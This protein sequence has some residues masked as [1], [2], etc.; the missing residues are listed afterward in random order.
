MYSI[1]HNNCS[2]ATRDVA[3]GGE[4]KG[5]RGGRSATETASW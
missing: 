3:I 1:W 2:E 5:E 4:G